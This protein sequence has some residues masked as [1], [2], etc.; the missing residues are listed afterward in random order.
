MG[1]NHLVVFFLVLVPLGFLT[2]FL[3]HGWMTPPPPPPAAA[4]SDLEPP[5]VPLTP[6]QL[7]GWCCEAGANACTK[8]DSAKVC[9]SGGGRTFAP[10]RAKC[11]KICAYLST[12]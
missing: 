3:L 8:S 4:S 7:L 1:R 5:E 9:L 11:D 10:D 6:E 12:R 2:G